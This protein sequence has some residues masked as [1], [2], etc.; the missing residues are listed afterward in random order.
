MYSPTCPTL[1]CLSP[2]KALWKL[3]RDCLTSRALAQCVLWSSALLYAS[4]QVSWQ[5][6][7]A[8]TFVGHGVLVI[9]LLRSAKAA[10]PPLVWGCTV[11]GRIGQRVRPRCQQRLR[12][13]PCPYS[14]SYIDLW[15]MP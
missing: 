9:P 11:F 5:I 14:I 3:Q 13:A 8:H 2:R 4:L 12:S 1:H 10:P 6:Q 7:D 15:S